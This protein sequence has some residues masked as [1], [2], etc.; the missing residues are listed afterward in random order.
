MGLEDAAD[1]FPVSKE[2]TIQDLVDIYGEE[3]VRRGIMYIDNLVEGEKRYLE[4]A[5]RSSYSNDL[6]EE[7]VGGE[8][9]EE[10]KE[11]MDSRWKDGM[12]DSGLGL[13]DE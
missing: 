12:R 13:N 11:D 7:V 1:D 5:G 6:A 3:A 4:A 9:P 2:T 10:Q 8:L